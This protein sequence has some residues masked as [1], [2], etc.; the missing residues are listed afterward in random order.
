MVEQTN[1]SLSESG[2]ILYVIVSYQPKSGE[3]SSPFT[4]L[5]A[6][7]T[8]SVERA[9]PATKY[10]LKATAFFS[11]ETQRVVMEETIYSSRNLFY[12]IIVTDFIIP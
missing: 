9:L 8:I 6:N 7:Q 11:N 4:I 3:P 12:L 5:P 1:Q 2:R 10:L